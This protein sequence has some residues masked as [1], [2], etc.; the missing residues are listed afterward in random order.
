MNNMQNTEVFIC[1]SPLMK[2]EYRVGKKYRWGKNPLGPQ[3]VECNILRRDKMVVLGDLLIDNKDTIRSQE[4]TPSWEHILFTCCHNQH[5]AL[6]PTRRR[7]LSWSDSWRE[8]IGHKQGARTVDAPLTCVASE[9][10]HSCFLH[11]GHLTV[12][13]AGFQR[14]PPPPPK[15]SQRAYN[16]KMCAIHMLLTVVTRNPPLETHIEAELVLTQRTL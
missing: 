6:P 3:F 5:L 1:T 8:I 4:E 11:I 9:T 2:Y 14:L 16:G 13:A 7:L 15:T 10:C 12:S